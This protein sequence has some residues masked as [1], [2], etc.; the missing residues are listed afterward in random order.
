[1]TWK[2]Y[3]LPWY[4]VPS[5]SENNFKCTGVGA[6]VPQSSS[7]KLHPA[8]RKKRCPAI[9]EESGEPPVD[10]T[11]SA[12]VACCHTQA[13]HIFSHSKW[14]IRLLPFP[15]WIPTARK[16]R[17]CREA[18]TRG[19]D[20]ESR[21]NCRSTNQTMLSEVDYSDLR[22]PVPA[23]DKEQHTYCSWSPTSALQENSADYIGC[24][25]DTGAVY[26]RYGWPCF[27]ELLQSVLSDSFSTKFC[28]V[29]WYCAPVGFLLQFACGKWHC[30]N[31]LWWY[32]VP[33]LTCTL[34]MVYILV[35]RC[36]CSCYFCYAIYIY[37]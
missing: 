24:N 26:C 18:R 8:G 17:S 27:S 12:A 10:S 28:P 30:T 36:I 15:D 33:E 7:C 1:M 6:L 21:Q 16:A 9:T 34:P 11:H 13:L 2:L 22:P 4:V 29:C 3:P 5:P 31:R 32:C 23:K 19:Y 37:I 14:T 35:C 25:Q 20:H